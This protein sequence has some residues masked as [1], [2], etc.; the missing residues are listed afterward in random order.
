[1]LACMPAIGVLYTYNLALDRLADLLEHLF[2]HGNVV[3]Y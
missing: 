1:M 3:F 2:R